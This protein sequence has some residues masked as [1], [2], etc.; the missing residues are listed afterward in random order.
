MKAAL[1]L[2]LSLAIGLSALSTPAHAQATLPGGSGGTGS[3][4]VPI[5][6]LSPSTGS[7]D[8]SLGIRFLLATARSPIAIGLAGRFQQP[9]SWRLLPR[10]A[11]TRGFAAQGRGLRIGLPGER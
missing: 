5:G 11:A 6:P 9:E 8:L 1:A 7:G 10:T 2:A 3:I 4:Q